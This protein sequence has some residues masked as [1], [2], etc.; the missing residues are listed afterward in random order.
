MVF[1]SHDNYISAFCQVQ[2]GINLS[3]NNSKLVMEHTIMDDEVIKKFIG[4]KIKAAR[5]NKNMT[6]Y[7]LAEEVGMDEKQLSRL[8]SG[9]HYPTLKTLL[10]IAKVLEIKL[11]DFDIIYD[12]KDFS[13]YLLLDILNKSSAKEIEKYLKII[14]TIKDM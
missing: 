9:K 7:A 6:Q 3:Q 5:I 8:E 10:A 12:N 11:A 4:A 13:F 1:L 14:K 2:Y